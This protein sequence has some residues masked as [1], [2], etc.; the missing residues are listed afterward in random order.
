ME[1]N[2]IFEHDL[3]ELLKN[4]TVKG[5]RVSDKYLCIEFDNNT[6]LEVE[7]ELPAD[8]NMGIRVSKTTRTKYVI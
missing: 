1:H 7:V 6:K 8:C 4:C 2:T 5:I 3:L